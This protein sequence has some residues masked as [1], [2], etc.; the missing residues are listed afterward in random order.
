MHMTKSSNS[1]LVSAPSHVRST[2]RVRSGSPFGLVFVC[3]ALLGSGT[4]FGCGTE[5][6]MDDAMGGT[7]GG[8]G[9][10]STPRPPL[11]DGP[12]PSNWPEANEYSWNGL[13]TPSFPIDG[14]LDDEYND[15][16]NGTPILPPGEWD[17]DNGN[18]D[19]ANW[20][21]FRDQFGDVSPL[22]DSQDRQYGWRIGGTED[23]DFQGPAAY[24]E[25]TPGVDYVDLGSTGWVHSFESGNLGAGPDVLIFNQSNS[26]DF[27]TGSDD[28]PGDNDDDLVIAGCLTRPDGGY[29]IRTTT[30]HTGPGHDWVFVRDIQAAAIDA[31]NGQ[32]GRTDAVDPGDG[33]DLVVLRGNTHDFRVFGGAGDD[34]AVWHLD[35]NVQNVTWLGPNFFGGGGWGD[36]L[37]NDNGTDRLVLA[38]P[39]DTQIVTQTPTPPGGL[40][41]RRA[42]D[43]FQSDAPTEH[44][45]FARYCVECGE[46]QDGQ[47]TMIFEYHS[48]DES[49]F[50]GYFYVTSFEE[51]QIGTGE[52]ARVYDIDSVAGTIT[53]N[54]ALKTIEPPA[55]FPSSYCQ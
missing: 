43:Q 17:W 8:G 9:G 29:D 20:R 33:D 47:R 48:K 10:G 52:G 7:G 50:T 30:I 15:G 2:L 22:V 36:A 3:C 6:G 54:T 18:N 23:L 32:S 5:G 34:I 19:L 45:M 39:T 41:V 26:L 51:L 28:R 11:A 38:I 53:E 13:W 44:D 1:I 37:F 31:G 27:R 24:F 49:V 16:H 25:G 21:N 55:T 14:L 46:A 4:L 40:L 42:G 35:D 12:D